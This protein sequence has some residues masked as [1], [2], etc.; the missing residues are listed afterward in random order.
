VLEV[1][2]DAGDGA[3]RADAGDENVDRAAG[4]LPDFRSIFLQ[5]TTTGGGFK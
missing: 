1:P 4:V 3:A 2:R 5:V